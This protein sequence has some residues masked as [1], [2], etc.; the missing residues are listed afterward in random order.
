MRNTGPNES[1]ADT[2]APTANPLAN[3]ATPSFVKASGIPVSNPAVNVP[4]A[5]EPAS[6]KQ[7]A[8]EPA[9]KADTVAR[10]PIPRVAIPEISLSSA[11]R[12]I[13]AADFSSAAAPAGSNPTA[14]NNV[15]SDAPSFTPHTVKPELRNREAVQ[16][17]LSDY[18]P[19]VLRERKI[20]GTVR[21]WVL[22]D[23]AGKVIRSQINE[24]SGNAY[25]DEAAAKVADVMTFTPALNRDQ[26][27][28]VW[29]QLP[30]IFKTK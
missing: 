8:S 7:V 19:P 16:R 12:Q 3:A 4:G 24:S 21:L 23:N 20:G 22:I 9:S 18:Y 15:V 27:V 11:G 1:D 5:T 28:S 30:I 10:L 26:K 13:N 29:I 17:A 14:A 25:L 6:D 2:A